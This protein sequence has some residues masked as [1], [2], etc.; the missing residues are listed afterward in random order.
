MSVS[1]NYNLISM[2]NSMQF[3][4]AGNALGNS[5]ALRLLGNLK[6]PAGGQNSAQA[7]YGGNNA[8]AAQP[9]QNSLKN[10]LDL[11]NGSTL[12][13]SSAAALS[14]AGSKQTA[15]SSNPGA[16]S[17][18]ARSGGAAALLKPVSIQVSRLASGQANQGTALNASDK[19]FAAGVQRFEIEQGGKTVSIS[20]SVE[21]N[22]TNRSVQ[23]KI[24]AEINRQN[25]GVTAE[26][27]AGESEGSAALV[28]TSAATSANEQ[29]RFTVRDTEGGNLAAAAGITGVTLEA[30]DAA[31][32]LNGAER[33]SS[34]NDIDLGFGVTAHLRQT[35]SEPVLVSQGLD[36]ANAQQA[37]LSLAEGFN[38]LSATAN[39]NNGSIAATRLAMRL[40]SIFS[41]S[42]SS[43]ASVG[44]TADENG[45]M[46]V[47]ASALSRAAENGALAKF[48]S[49]SG[50][51]L[52]N[53]LS[54]V[55]D[56]VKRDPVAF[57]GFNRIADTF[58]DY[59]G[60][61][62]SSSF[63]AQD[64]S[65]AGAGAGKGYFLNVLV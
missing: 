2:Y 43:L 24:A 11:K 16:V 10:L 44:V 28:L 65:Y 31:Y 12:L 46:E 19:N 57:A 48:L 55:A 21:E 33:T 35:T 41:A 50:Q 40:N 53:R 62:G 4:H 32:T 56:S 59:L 20:V 27:R 7:L 64:F 29:S 26:V 61:S 3:L 23:D 22:D 17:V 54:G 14:K 30:R 5:S 18:S 39:E 47:N 38:T 1:G 49:S 42:A 45:R 15:V 51:S 13:S 63:A 60:G 58:Y 6:T 52:A 9:V 37:L 34:T 36:A 25:S 8:S